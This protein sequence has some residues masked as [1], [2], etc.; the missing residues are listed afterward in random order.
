MAFLQ[1][2]GRS[3]TVEYLTLT[4]TGTTAKSGGFSTLTTDTVTDVVIQNLS[5]Q[6]CYITF[7]TA[8]VTATSSHLYL[9]ANSSVSLSNS[10]FAYFSV[11]RATATNVSLRVTGIGRV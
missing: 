5:A 6:A 10:A 8:A 11:I 1:N 7:G 3:N 9:A 4:T 2:L